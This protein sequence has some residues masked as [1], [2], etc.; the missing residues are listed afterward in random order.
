MREVLKNIKAVCAECGTP[1][2]GKNLHR[3]GD[4]YYCSADYE[5]LSPEEKMKND[6]LKREVERYTKIFG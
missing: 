6:E 1:L 4:Y 5:R 2:Y 3:R